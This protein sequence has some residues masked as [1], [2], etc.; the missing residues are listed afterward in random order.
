LGEYTP[1]PPPGGSGHA[2]VAVFGCDDH[3]AA[4][5]NRGVAGK[6]VTGVDAD[7]GHQAAELAPVGKREA[8]E[9][10]KPHAIGIARATAAAFGEE[11]H[12]QLLAFGQ[13]KHAVF[14]A[15][16]LPALGAS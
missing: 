11:H 7:H 5:Q 8:I 15:V 12:R 4:G 1:R 2:D 6:A 14:L 9:A 13:L 3:V 16:V 10:S